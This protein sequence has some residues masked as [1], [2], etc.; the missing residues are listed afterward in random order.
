M[1]TV[2]A[3]ATTRIR[4]VME[5]VVLAA[6]MVAVM[7]VVSQVTTRKSKNDRQTNVVFYHCFDRPIC[8]TAFRHGIG[9]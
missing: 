4:V 1:D 7:V 9:Q 2:L 3:V 5:A 8:L 6:V